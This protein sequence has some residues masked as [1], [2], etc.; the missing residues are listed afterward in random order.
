MIQNHHMIILCIIEKA[1]LH[2]HFIEMYPPSLVELRKIHPI[3]G[4][5]RPIQLEIPFSHSHT[6]KTANQSR[7]RR[8]KLLRETQHID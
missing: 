1:I 6:E 5:N 7:G 4:S 8:K 3:Q 2:N